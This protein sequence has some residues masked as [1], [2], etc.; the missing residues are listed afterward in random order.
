MTGKFHTKHRY[1]ALQVMHAVHLFVLYIVRGMRGRK[2]K[3]CK[4]NNFILL[5][6]FFALP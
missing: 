1:I 5:T 3:T 6:C 2:K 4:Q